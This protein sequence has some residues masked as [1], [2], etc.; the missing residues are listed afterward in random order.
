MYSL[1]PFVQDGLPWWLRWYRIHLQCRRSG[2]NPWVGDPLEE[3]MATHCSIPAW[4]I[5]MD[6]GVWQAT[7]HGVAKSWI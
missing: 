2:F 4:R 3:D 6:R 5:P 1:S 7:V